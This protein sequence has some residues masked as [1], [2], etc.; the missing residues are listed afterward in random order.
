MLSYHKQVRNQGPCYE[1]SVWCLMKSKNHKDAKENLVSSTK[2]ITALSKNRL[3]VLHVF[4]SEKILTCSVPW[5][6]TD[7]LYCFFPN[8]DGLIS[9]EEMMAYF[10][11]AKSQFQCKMGPGFIHNFQ[12]MT[13]LKPTFCEHCAGFVSMFLVTAHLTRN[14]VFFN[15]DGV[16]LVPCAVTVS[17]AWPNASLHLEA[18][19]ISS[20]CSCGTQFCFGSSWIQALVRITVTGK[21][22]KIMLTKGHR[23]L[24]EWPYLVYLKFFNLA[25]FPM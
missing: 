24:Y 4:C 6:V 7:L 5:A 10:L 3:C 1:F 12:E 13:Y 22:S 19:S 11:R 2:T 9:K 21:E 25:W 23:R 18:Q 16:K 8:R 17:S 20:C 15:V 14:F